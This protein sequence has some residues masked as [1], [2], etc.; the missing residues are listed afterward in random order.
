MIGVSMIWYIN[1]ARVD[2]KKVLKMCGDNESE[3]IREKDI[4]SKLVRTRKIIRNKF[5]KAY[6]DRV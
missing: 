4:K 1:A 6:K 3:I 5:K 2:K